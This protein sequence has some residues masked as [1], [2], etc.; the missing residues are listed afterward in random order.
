MEGAQKSIYIFAYVYV[1]PPT[2]RGRTM[3]MPVGNSCTACPGVKCMDG[4]DFIKVYDEFE[5]GEDESDEEPDEEEGGEDDD[6]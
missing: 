1:Q 3:A 2:C 5:G 6:Y 4:L